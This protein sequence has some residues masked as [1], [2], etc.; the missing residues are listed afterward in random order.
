MTGRKFI[1]LFKKNDFNVW[2]NKRI[3]FMKLKYQS[4]HPM[5]TSNFE[6]IEMRVFI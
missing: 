5:I 1:C 3:F 2:L 6:L 4:L